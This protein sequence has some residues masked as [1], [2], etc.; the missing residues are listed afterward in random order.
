MT[1]LSENRIAVWL[2]VTI[3][4]VVLLRTAWLCDDAYITLRTIDNFVHGLGLTWNAAERVQT[5]THPLWLLVLSIPYSFTF[6]AFYTTLIV[7]MMVSLMA[8]YLLAFRVASTNFVAVLVVFALCLSKAF[9]DFSTSGLENPLTHL[10]LVIFFGLFLKA[11][12]TPGCIL[13]LS[14]LAALGA[15]NRLDILL[16]FGPVL[17]Y[18]F[19][20]NRN[21][22]T[23]RMI[24]LGLSP[25]ILWECFSLLY[26]GALFPNTAY[27]KL[28]TGIDSWSIVQQGLRYLWNSCRVSIMTPL[29]FV[30]AAVWVVNKR[31][32]RYWSAFAGI[33]LYIFYIAWVGGDF[34]TGRF[35]SAPL[36]V[37]VVILSQADISPK[38]P[39]WLGGAL[40]IL[41]LGLIWPGSPL[42]TGSD[43]GTKKEHKLWDHGIGGERANYFQSSGLLNDVPSDQ[44]RPVHPWKEDGKKLAAGDS[45]VVSRAGVGFYGYY[46]GPRIHIVDE[47]ALGDPLLSRLP[48]RTPNRWRIGHFRRIVPNGYLRSIIADS[49]L[50]ED[51]SLAEFYDK[52]RLITRGAIFDWTRLQAIV[53]MNL[54]RYDH[55]LNSYTSKPLLVETYSAVQTRRPEGF[56]ALGNACFLLPPTG[57]LVSFDSVRHDLHIELSLDHNDD[58]QVSFFRDTVQLA[59]LAFPVGRIPGGGLRVVVA[60]VPA[61]AIKK[62]FDRIEIVGRGDS[63]PFSVGHLHLFNDLDSTIVDSLTR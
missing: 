22:K 52:L 45:F 8:V 7:S 57:M 42:F 10:I 41:V 38:K 5:F 44:D 51:K 21:W 43:F 58:Y 16:I 35:L 13:W 3:F 37:A 54:G 12:Q 53:N 40:V 28:N 25:L 29:L 14:L 33:L 18:V 11:A 48:A 26:Y 9:V 24:M 62:G 27:A 1:R 30:A 32:G 59:S 17:L 6:E 20:R 63:G 2:S 31:S 19:A 34:M 50:I 36:L 61:K 56:P 23:V 47:H 60:D 15:V 4:A 46:A 49:N 55:L 39:V